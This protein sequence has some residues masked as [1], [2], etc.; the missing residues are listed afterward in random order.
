MSRSEAARPRGKPAPDDL[1]GLLVAG[2]EDYAI[3]T[4][5]PDGLVTSW[6][7]GAQRCK[8]YAP[9]EIIGRHF[10]VF[11]APDDIAAGKP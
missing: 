1:L 7:A 2:V 9:E 8:G 4:L 3:L 5:D 6:N 11:Y 10:S